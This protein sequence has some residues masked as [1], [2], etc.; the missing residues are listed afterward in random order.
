MRCVIKNDLLISVIIP[1]HNRKLLLKNAIDSVLNQ[2]YQKFEIII[3]DDCSTDGTKD[4]VLSLK[5]ARIKYFRNE[6]NLYA[7]AS[8]NVGIKNSNGEFIAFLDDDDEWFP[9]KLEKQIPIF[10]NEKVGL[11]YSSINLF[12]EAYNFSY[13]TI[14]TKKGLICKDMLIKNYIGGT[15]SVIVRKQALQELMD[16]EWFNPNFPAREEYDLWIRLSKSWKVDYI[17]KPLVRAYYRNNIKRISV[18]INSYVR[19]IE[20]L[21]IKYEQEVEKLLT[22]KEKKNRNSIQQFFL[23]SQAI[24]LGNTTL[25][26][27]Y[28]WKAFRIN[29]NKKAFISYL[30]SLFSA[31]AVIISRYYFDKIKFIKKYL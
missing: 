15:V 21:N 27:K 16:V 26:R 19:G 4:Y 18:D 23:G 8:R 20:L 11:V 7:A 29:R 28:F 10:K 22:I 6:K 13:N 5:D 30:L 3:V 1:T 12:F 9:Q 25:A 2:T 17:S 24:K 31:K 14:P